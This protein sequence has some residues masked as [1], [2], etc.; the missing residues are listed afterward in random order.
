M[1]T[2]LSLMIAAA[3]GLA[4]QAQQA[5]TVPTPVD[6]KPAKA[7]CSKGSTAGCQSAAAKSETAAAAAPAEKGKACYSKDHAAASCESKGKSKPK[8]RKEDN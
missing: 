8:A 5:N 7:C 1:K 4:A 2:I 3:F 6:S